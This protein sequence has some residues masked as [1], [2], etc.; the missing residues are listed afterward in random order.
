MFGFGKALDV[1]RGG[2]AVRRTSW[3]FEVFDGHTSLILVPGSPELTV[4]AGRPLGKALP[5]LVGETMQYAA[6]IDRINASG[7]AVWATPWQPT[8]DD[9]LAEDWDYA[10]SKPEPVDD[11]EPHG[12]QQAEHWPQAVPASMWCT[13]DAKRAK[14]NSIIWS[15]EAT[16]RELGLNC[17]HWVAMPADWQAPA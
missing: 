9:L 7:V 10:G 16:P 11:H 6:H 15:P 12:A 14:I 5:H 2:D 8:Q 1:L 3:N 4:D 17:G 13:V